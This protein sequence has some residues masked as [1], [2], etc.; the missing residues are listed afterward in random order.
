MRNNNA[1]WFLLALAWAAN[2]FWLSTDTFSSEHTH[3]VLSRLLYRVHIHLAPPVL[4]ATHTVIRK[5][6]HVGEYAVLA[7]LLYPSLSGRKH[8]ARWVLLACLAYAFTDELHQAFVPGRGPSLIDCAIDVAG[9]ALG[10]LLIHVFRHG[11]PKLTT[12]VEV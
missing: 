11:P 1:L 7:L 8:A 5:L 12:P 3:P 9:A 10:A 6:A 4:D 2:M